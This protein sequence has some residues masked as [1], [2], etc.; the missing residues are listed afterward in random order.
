MP[1]DER[2]AAEPTSAGAGGDGEVEGA[3][4]SGAGAAGAAAVVGGSGGSREPGD[5]VFAAAGRQFTCTKGSNGKTGC[6]MCIPRAHPIVETILVTSARDT[7]PDP[8]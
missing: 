3:G 2:N 7:D 4:G 1:N 5:A 8:H 6:R